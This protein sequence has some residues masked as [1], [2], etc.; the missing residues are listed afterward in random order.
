[1]KSAERLGRL[2][3]AAGRIGGDGCAVEIEAGGAGDVSR[4]GA[5]V[6]GERLKDFRAG[7]AVA[8]V[9]SAGDDG[10]LRG[11]AGQELRARG[12][13]AAVMAGFQERAG[14]AGLGQHG[15]LDGGFG[16]AFEK[17]GC[18]AVSGVQDERIV[19]GWLGAGLI[20]GERGEHGDL[21]GAEVECVS[22]ME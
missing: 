2:L 3:P 19:V 17:N 20:R 7:M 10:P 13:E 1:V 4:V 22:G 12:G 14:E 11:N 8:V 15:L 6:G 18:C 21:R 5:G 9:E 16:I